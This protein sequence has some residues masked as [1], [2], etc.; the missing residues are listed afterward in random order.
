MPRGELMRP[1]RIT[2]KPEADLLSRMAKAG[3]IARVWRGVYSVPLRLPLGGRWSPSEALALRAL[4][5][6]RGGRYQICAPNA[7]NRYGFDERIVGLTLAAVGV[8]SIIVNGAIVGPVTK[9]VGERATLMIGLAFASVVTWTIWLAKTIGIFIAKRRARA[10]LRALTAARSL[11]DVD[12]R[13]SPATEL[14]A[15]VREELQLS[16]DVL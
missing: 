7:F 10:A 6:D 15:A 1:L 8:G 16:A 12:A 13:V 11:A 4:M 2:A 3:L 5:E 14:V 9:Q